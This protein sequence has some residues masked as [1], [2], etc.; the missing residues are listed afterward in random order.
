VSTTL[1]DVAAARARFSALDRRLAFF[2]GPGG[3]QCPDEVIDAIASYLRE[4]N[5]NIGAPY[6]TSRR[7]DEL[8]ERAHERAASFLGCSPG[9]TAFGQ[10]M[11]A[12]N[13]LLTRAFGRALREGDEVVVTALDHDGNVSPW[14][15]LAHD[16]GIVVRVAGLTGELEV[17]YA[18]LESKLSART[19][20]L[21]FPIAANSV[22]TAPDV[23]RIVDLAHGA[24]ALAWAD[25]V[26]Y[27]PHGPI[28]VSGW[29]VDVLICS[30][31]KFFGPHMG[32]AFGKSEL[33]ESWR[34]YKVRPAANE[35]VGHRF[36]LGT[37]QHELLAGFVAAVDY[38]DSLGWDAIVS[39]ER[40]L[41]ERFLAGLPGAVELYGLRT[42]DGRVPTFCFN[43]P[44]RSA[45]AVATALAAHEIA[46]WHGDYYAV[47]TMKHLGLTDGAVRAGIVHYNTEEEVDR[48]L[49][50]LAELT[51]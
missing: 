23:R 41:G 38:V 18:D 48:L 36:E 45:E 30:P 20:V 24:G 31:Y 4:D 12:M 21:A 15:E 11:T 1:L 46:V 47:E 40:E 35:P 25:A 26:H 22:G 10:S 28:D 39:H 33:L 14:L 29:D 16:L 7:T 13:F 37:S 42:M 2:D 9:E 43:V 32:L 5:A 27:G 19:R 50:G 6:E 8:V 34:P 17:D 44:G 51:R 49:D 3:T